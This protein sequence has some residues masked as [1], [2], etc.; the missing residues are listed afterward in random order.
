MQPKVRQLTCA[1]KAVG[2]LDL[3]RQAGGADLDEPPAVLPKL[4]RAL[5]KVDVFEYPIAGL[6]EIRMRI[7]A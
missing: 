7:E 3:V 5:D 1:V 6:D 2:E 4:F